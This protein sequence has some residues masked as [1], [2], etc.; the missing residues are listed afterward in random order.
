MEA[1]VTKLRSFKRRWVT[2]AA[3]AL[4]APML[5]SSQ[6]LASKDAGAAGTPA[7]FRVNAQGQI[8][9]NGQIYQIRGGSWF[10][11][12]G[13]YEPASDSTNP[14]GAPMEQ[15]IGN[16][17]WAPSGRTITQDLNE[18]KALGINVIR[19]PLSHQTLDAND[20]QGR[21][22]VLKND[23]S[24]RIA[25][26]RL[27][28]ETMI[29][30]ADAAGIDVMLD[31]HSCSNYVDWRK[32]RLDARPPYVDAERDNY[33]FKR[34][35]SSC[36]STNNPSTVTRIQPYNET[37]WLQDLKT[38]AGFSST[39]GVSNIIGI[40]IFNEPWD[41]TWEEWKTLTEHAYTA[42]NEVNP[43]ILIFTQGISATAGNQDGT[44]D[45]VT[46]VPHGGGITPNWGENLF[47]AGA[48][49]PNVPKERLVF[50]PHAYGPSVFVGAQFMDPAQP[51]CAGL[52]GDAAGDAKCN[53]VINPTLLR[54]GWDE[55]FGYL[56]A[57]GYAVVI[58]EF[59]GNV[60]WPGGGAT[61]RDKNRFGYLTD[62]TT[63]LKWQTAFVDYLIDRGITDTVYWSINPES[64]DTGGLYTSPYIAGSNESAW[65][66]WGT[67]DTRK[68]NL[69]KRLW[70]V[71]SVP[72][73]PVTVTPTTPVTTTPVTVTPTKT[74]TAT[75][76]TPTPVT[77]TPTPVTVTPTKTPVTPTATPVTP[78]AT[79]VTPTTTPGGACS[80]VSSTISG[81]FSYDG[82]G[83]FCWK[84]SSLGSYVNS[85]NLTKLTINGVDFT[86]KWASSGSFPAAIDG[87]WY[88]SYTGP[89]A[90]SHF[91]AK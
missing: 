18:M 1:F 7:V 86:N 36:A 9:K 42:I 25:N 24:V 33:D 46:Q 65:G 58:G 6:G 23:P 17:W 20:P 57:M 71:G 26:S 44:P 3:V 56:K 66:T 38:L 69:L 50:T 11:L 70:A 82:A 21:E 89:Y 39:L 67:W 12:Q 45:T 8:T 29:K 37:I 16:V 34:E 35:D 4:V 88:V 53:I 84:A 43:N 78:T 22:P 81:P 49:P 48:N 80:P 60:D 91:E 15:Y 54:Q 28:L 52:E 41:Y 59:G 90:W 55:H 40:D 32:G 51:Q 10:G 62:K 76:V 74:V 2:A 75:P 5:L 64:G 61:L 85:W 77:V 31:I 19:L 73:T 83:T 14:R 79:P 87:Y 72:G 27:A 68:T 47:E 13:R 63:D 30:A